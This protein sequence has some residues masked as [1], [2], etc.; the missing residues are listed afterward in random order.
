MIFTRTILALA[1]TGLLFTGC[2]QNGSAPNVDNSKTEASAKTKPI[3]PDKL[4]TASFT[5]E[6]M[7][8][9]V[10]CAKTIEKE[11]AETAGVQKATVD[12]DKKKA[13]VEFDSS[14]QTPENLIK[15]VEATADG[16]TYKVSDLKSSKDHAMLLPQDQDQDDQKSAKKKTKGDK[17]SCADDAK[18]AKP[19]CCA[20]KKH[21]S[22][23]EKKA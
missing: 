19:G 12:F 15:I 4:E 18:S 1:F 11:L 3:N 10:G 14:Q 8:C 9:A 22:M 13:T 17:K 16:K 20:G 7:T 21:C 6:G 23:D 5:V 2:K